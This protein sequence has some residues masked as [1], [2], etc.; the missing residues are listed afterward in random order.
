[1]IKN[2]NHK[3]IYIIID[4]E[5]IFTI[6][7]NYYFLSWQLNFMINLQSLTFI[8]KLSIYFKIF[9][10]KNKNAFIV[11][12]FRRQMLTTNISKGFYEIE[13]TL[14]MWNLWCCMIFTCR[15]IIFILF[16]K[17][18]RTICISIKENFK[19]HSFKMHIP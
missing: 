15:I 7:Q 6:Q 16:K 17:L 5:N 9:Q 12:Y 11:I 18:V 3:V 10:K 13:I 14:M 8:L 1:M 19:F 2:N 4:E